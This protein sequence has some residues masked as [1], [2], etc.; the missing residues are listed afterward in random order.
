MKDVIV[1]SEKTN[2]MG[3]S[4]M[5]IVDILRRENPGDNIHLVDN[6]QDL[7]QALEENEIGLAMLLK[8]AELPK[9][10]GMAVMDISFLIYSQT[11]L[12]EYIFN[13]Y[14][15]STSHH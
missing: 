6:E 11:T 3:F 8:K 1:Y 5:G 10:E 2:Y 12:I 14:K 13:A 15:L 4:V 9:K 7:A